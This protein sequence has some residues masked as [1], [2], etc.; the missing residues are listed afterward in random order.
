[1]LHGH[2]SASSLLRTQP[3]PSRLRPTSRC[4]RL[5][6]FPA[7]AISRRGEKGLSSCSASPCHRAVP[8]NP[9]EVAGRISPCDTPCCL[10]PKSEGSAFGFKHSRGHMGSLALRPG[11]SLTILEDG[12]V[13]RL[14]DI[15]FPSCLLFKLRGFGLLPRWDSHPQVDASL[16]WTHT[17]LCKLCIF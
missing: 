10:R 8:T 1:L 2:Y 4:L 13:N 9:A 14:Q 6:G 12:F 11:H 17:N 5:Y 16:C 15:Q 3:I 7:P